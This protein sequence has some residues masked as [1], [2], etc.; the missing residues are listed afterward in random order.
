[1]KVFRVMK[2][3]TLLLFIVLCN[4][5][6][7]EAHAQKTKISL[8]ANDVSIKEVLKEIEK[9]SEF[10]FF[11]NDLAINMEQRVSV[12]AK[13]KE[14]REVLKKILPQCLLE[15][16]GQRI[17]IIP[18]ATTSVEQSNTRTISGKVFDTNGEGIIGANVIEKGTTNGTITDIDGNFTLTVTNGAQLQ[19]SFIGYI[20][21]VVQVKDQSSFSIKLL[22]DATQ[23]EEVVVTGFGLSQKKATL[24]GAISSVRSDDL[25][26]SL[27]TNT[28]GA[29][30]GKI[31]GLNFRQA[32]SRPGNNTTIEIRNMGEPLFIIDGSQ[33]DVGQFN[34]IDFNDIESISILK[35]ASASI[36]GVRAANGVVVVTTK[37]GKK[38]TKN[39]ITVNTYY[40]WQKASRFPDPADAETYVKSYIQ[41]ETIQDKPNRTYSKEDL[42]KWRQGTEK[43]YRPFDWA[44]FIWVTSPQYYA[45]IN[46][47]GGSDK[48]SYYFSLGHLNQESIVRNYG[49]MKRTNIQ[50]NVDAEITSKL[51]IGLTMNGRIKDQKNPGVPGTDDYNLPLVGSYRNLPTV[52]PFAN[53]NPKYPAKTNND[54]TMNFGLLNYD[55]SGTYRDTWR[56]AQING[57]IEYEILKG[58]KLKG[59]FGYYLA[60]QKLDNQEYVYKIYDYDEATDTYPVIGQRSS[61]WKERNIAMVEELTSNIQ[62]SYDKSIQGHSIA[63][64]LGFEAIKRDAP[65]HWFHSV[66]A[67]DALHLFDYETI[68]RVTD[69]GKNTEARLGWLG[70]LNYDFH[71]KYLIEFSA[72]YDGSWKFPPGDRWGFFPSGSIGWRISEETFWKESKLAGI[73]NDLKVRGSYGLLGDDNVKDYEAFGYMSGYD[74]NK[75]R[76]SG[77]EKLGGVL[78][79]KF[80]IGAIPRNFPVR[81]LSWIKAKILDIGF[82]AAFLDGRL[83]FSFDYFDRIRTGL[84]DSRYDVLLPSEYGF[85]LPKENLNSSKNKG[86]D[87]SLAWSDKIQDFR[88]SVGTTM[89]FSRLYDWEQYKPRYSNSW[90]YYRNSKWHRYGNLNWGLEAAGQFQSWEE[91]ATYEIDNDRKGNAT[92]RPGDIKY[93][94][95]NKDGVINSLDERPIGYQQNGT[96]NLNFGIALSAGWKNFDLAADFTG[97]FMTTWYQ[98]AIQRT[99]FNNGGNN[100]MFYMGDA[101]GLSDIFDASSELIPGKYPTLLVGNGGHSNYWNSAFWKTNV[102]YIKLRNLVLGYTIPKAILE[103]ARVSDLRIYVSAQNLF[104]ITNVPVDP[105]ISATNGAAYPTTRIINLGLTLKF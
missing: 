83:H 26:R 82:D 12:V 6:A 92:L 85:N 3:T 21:Q 95:Q 54:Y 1:M 90:D 22:E 88:Y 28:S 87:F 75:L 103:R 41:S 44:D 61:A 23:L 60:N 11:Y 79:G 42:E 57:N 97:A 66:P 32:D 55:I 20:E 27:S 89:T 36:Y 16:D 47:S 45:N 38:N 105:E 58:L 59:L 53:D 19:I 69:T 91:I 68:D 50:F 33:K 14:I 102:R 31:S 84:P 37:K 4:V 67:S 48:I 35:D 78:D 9:Q 49:G 17:I 63:A 8:Q 43:N 93:V 39:T 34:N 62:V 99:P 7:H 29:L 98:E 72:R 76:E 10:T 80:V 104:T 30:A 86:Y 15:V 24:T 2:I 101:W 52:R 94:D 64:V 71:N 18:A 77:N 46:V 65:S 40:G 96:P 73:F 100:P 13:N 56:I 25:S 5:A 70:R 81:T 51:K 74:Y